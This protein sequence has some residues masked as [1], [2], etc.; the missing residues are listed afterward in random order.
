MSAIHPAT[1]VRVDD[2]SFRVTC[3]RSGA[4]ALF[5]PEYLRSG[6]SGHATWEKEPEADSECH[7]AYHENVKKKRTATARGPGKG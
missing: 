3:E 7:Y 2:V 4:V 1:F 5:W 6:G